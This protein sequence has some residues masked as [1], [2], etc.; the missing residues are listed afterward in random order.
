MPGFWALKACLRG[1]HVRFPE[2]DALLFRL[3]VASL[4]GRRCLCRKK[5]GRGLIL[6]RGLRKASAS[7]SSWESS[8]CGAGVIVSYPAMRT[9]SIRDLT[10]LTRQHLTT[11]QTAQDS[12]NEH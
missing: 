7:D 1:L 11:H 12:V 4:A 2:K 6:P 8:S 10:E 9:D 3:V 5:H